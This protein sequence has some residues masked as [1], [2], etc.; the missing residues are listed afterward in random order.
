[1][2]VLEPKCVLNMVNMEIGMWKMSEMAGR[3]NMNMYSV[4]L[5]IAYA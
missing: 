4:G 1:M 5:I 3:E 2:D